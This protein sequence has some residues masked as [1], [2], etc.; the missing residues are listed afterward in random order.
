MKYKLICIDLDGTML[1]NNH[2]ISLYN[3]NVIHRLHDAGYIV[4]VVTGRR[5]KSALPYTK[6]LAI[7]API[8]CFNG[9]MIVDLEHHRILHTTS[10]SRDYVQQVLKRWLP[11]GAPIF[12]YKATLDNPDVLHQNRSDHPAIVKYLA[13]QYASGALREVDSLEVAIDFDP[14]CMKT[15]GWERDVLL[16]E[17]ATDLSDSA[18]VQYLKSKDYD[19]SCHYY[20]LYP[21]AAKKKHGL[22]WLCDYYGFK[23]QEVLAIGD[24]YNDLDMIEWAGLGIA[25]GNAVPELKALADRVTETN[26]EDGVGRILE[27]V[28]L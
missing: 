25:M 24:N 10:I 1:D 2:R 5:F 9:G 13:S 19:G 17:G 22:I 15:F 18:E 4:A 26:N 8:I 3:Q 23:Q 12:A 28:L 21:T 27:Q 14:L 7:D 11:T 6:Q 16:C 20:E